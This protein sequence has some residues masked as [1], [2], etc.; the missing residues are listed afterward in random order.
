MPANPAAAAELVKQALAG[1]PEV[2]EAQAEV[3]A[4]QHAVQAALHNNAPS[5]AVVASVSTQRLIP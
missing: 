2:R 3:E 1:R 5:V 4:Q